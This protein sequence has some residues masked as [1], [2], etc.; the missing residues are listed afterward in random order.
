MK[1][2]LISTQKGLGDNIYQRPFIKTLCKT[3]EVYLKTPWVQLYKDLPIKFVKDS[4]RL[5][6][7]NKNIIR[8]DIDVEY[9]DH[10]SCPSI[11]PRY[12]PHELRN[13]SITMSLQKSYNCL[14][15][16]FDLPP[17]ETIKIDTDKPICIVRP[18]TVRTEW[19]ASARN[20]LPEYIATAAKIAME[21]YFVISIADIDDKNEVGLQ[22]LPEAHLTFNKGELTVEQVLGLIQKA[23][24]VIGGVG[25]IV[26]ACIATKTNLFCIQGGN[27]GYNSVNVITDKSMDLSKIKFCRP[28]SYCI[29][30]ISTHNCTKTISNFENKFK[31]YLNDI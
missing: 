14:P 28:D 27:G 21:K 9:V 20:P 26:P 4:T 8:E 31:D 2:L 12:N 19:V 10:P 29:C 17:F 7:Q 15:D 3:H 1:K 24:L 6:T 23:D 18:A 11:E 25:F 30:T 13:M 16:T 22:P 5:R